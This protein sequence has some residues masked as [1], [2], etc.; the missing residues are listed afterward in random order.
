MANNYGYIRGGAGSLSINPV[1]NF[2]NTIASALHLMGAVAEEHARIDADVKSVT[3]LSAPSLVK[4]HILIVDLDVGGLAGETVAVIRSDTHEILFHPDHE[5]L[6]TQ[7][8]NELKARSSILKLGVEAKDKEVVYSLDAIAKQCFGTDRTFAKA[9][10]SCVICHQSADTFKDELSKREFE[11]SGMC[12]ACQD[13]TFQTETDSEYACSCGETRIGKTDK[14]EQVCL[15]CFK[16]VE[17]RER[18]KH[19]EHSCDDKPLALKKRKIYCANCRELYH[20]C[21]CP[22]EQYDFDAE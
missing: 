7:L 8:S 3:G 19:K 9:M 13:A 6:S 17:L 22:P 4:P 14:G 18:L 16:R 5:H 15:S 20:E 1:G 12:Q 21:K 2:A 10:K 11:I